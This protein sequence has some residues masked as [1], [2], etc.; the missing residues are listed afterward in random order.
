MSL[1]SGLSAQRGTFDGACSAYQF[2]NEALSLL[3]REDRRKVNLCEH[4]LDVRIG[5]QP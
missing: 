3:C 1:G 5:E 2:S 4:L